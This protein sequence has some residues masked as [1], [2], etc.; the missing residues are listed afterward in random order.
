MNDQVTRSL[1]QGYLLA[2]RAHANTVYGIVFQADFLCNITRWHG[3]N[4]SEENTAPYFAKRTSA[5]SQR[6]AIT[7][8]GLAPSPLSMVPR[9]CSMSINRAARAYPI[10]GFRHR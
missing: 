8:R 7:F 5:S 4:C 1:I 2:G 9:S 3:Q 6:K 10:P